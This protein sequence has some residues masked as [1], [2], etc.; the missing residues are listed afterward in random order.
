VDGR[1]I[2][3]K[4]G[5]RLEKRDQH[6][7]KTVPHFETSVQKCCSEIEQ[8][9][10]GSLGLRIPNSPVKFGSHDFRNPSGLPDLLFRRVS[11][12]LR[13]PDVPVKT[14]KVLFASSL[15]APGLLPLLCP[16]PAI[17]L[18]HA[19]VSNTAIG[20]VQLACQSQQSQFVA[21]EDTK[22]YVGRE[23]TDKGENS[24]GVSIVTPFF[25]L[26]LCASVPSVAP[27]AK[28][29]GADPRGLPMHWAAGKPVQ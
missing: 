7:V 27:T 20:R 15:P 23:K 9:S 19:F 2:L 12:V 26:P 10:W 4:T 6:T 16:S 22:E 24:G 29:C 5:G 21:A 11:P 8:A 28:T 1:G 3:G 25:F 17:P 18:P 14:A 13:T